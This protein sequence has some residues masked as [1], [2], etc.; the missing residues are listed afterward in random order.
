MTMPN[1][2][3]G[4]PANAVGSGHAP[5]GADAHALPSAR[6]KS[7]LFVTRS[8]EF[9]GAERHT[10]DLIGRLA[11]KAGVKL[12]MLC[13]DTDSY[14]R[15]FIGKQGVSVTVTDGR[16]LR[17][18]WDWYLAF[19]RLRPDALVLIKSWAWCFPWYT[20]LAAQFA[21]IGRRVAIAHL[22][23]SP[24]PAAGFRR[25]R[26]GFGHRRLSVACDTMICV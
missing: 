10:L 22:P 12:S 26:Y 25:L 20:C 23:P 2:L 3:A 9:G 14:S 19:R 6:Q 5:G 16:N 13:T 8:P 11:A 24:A 1:A 4:A 17:S 7:I 15:H 18:P 21:E